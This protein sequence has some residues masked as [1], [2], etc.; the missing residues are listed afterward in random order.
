MNF[1][2]FNTVQHQQ[3]DFMF[4]AVFMSRLQILL[5][6]TSKSSKMAWKFVGRFPRKLFVPEYC[7]KI[8]F[9]KKGGFSDPIL[10][11]LRTNFLSLIFPSYKKVCSTTNCALKKNAH[12]HSWQLISSD[13]S[14]WIRSTVSKGRFFSLYSTGPSSTRRIAKS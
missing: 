14:L 10:L 8:E 13:F 2:F 11:W 9:E 12:R 7:P 4:Y 6:V 5:Y 3:L 1:T